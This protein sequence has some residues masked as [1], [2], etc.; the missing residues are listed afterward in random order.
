VD[1]VLTVTATP[2]FA[3]AVGQAVGHATNR[4]G[5]PGS[6]LWVLHDDCAPEPACLDILLRAAEASPAAG[7]LGPLTVDW[8]D[9]RLV[10]DAGV[11]TDASGHRRRVVTDTADGGDVPD[12]ETAEILPEQTTE[13]LAVPSAGA[14]ISRQLWEQLDGYDR[15]LRVFAEDVD[16]GWRANVAGSLVLNVPAAR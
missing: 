14:L 6:W 15:E 10:V 12:G 5:D 9:P 4:W 11:S 16:F 3:E 2:G 8:T 1:G 13:V 7:V